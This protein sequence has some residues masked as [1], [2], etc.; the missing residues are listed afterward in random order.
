ME[1]GYI[2]LSMG[3]FQEATDIFEAVEVLSPKNE[4]PLVAQGTVHFARMKYEEAIRFYKR[5]LRLK[6]ESAFAR[7]YLGEAYFFMGKEKEAMK[8]LQKA[9]QLDPE[10]TAGSF[11]RSLQEAIQKGFNPPGKRELRE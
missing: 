3:K 11:A 2:Y 5:G 8:E 6:S 4:I 7:T 9:S 1:A 10:G